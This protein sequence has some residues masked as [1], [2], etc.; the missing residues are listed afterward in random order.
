MK[1]GIRENVRISLPQEFIDSLFPFLRHTPRWV[2]TSLT[3]L[4]FPLCLPFLPGG[5]RGNEFLCFQGHLRCHLF[6]E[7]FSHPH[8]QL[9]QPSSSSWYPPLVEQCC[10]PS[11]QG[12]VLCPLLAQCRTH[13]DALVMFTACLDIQVSAVGK[14][15]Q[16][17]TWNTDQLKL[18]LLP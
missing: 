18:V 8:K 3:Q 12:C 15:D 14:Y 13:S 4:T 16:N 5:R 11:R 10:G 17:S 2:S 6:C 1:A 9:P 7:A